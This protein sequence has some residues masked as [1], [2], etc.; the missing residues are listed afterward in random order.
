MATLLEVVAVVLRG[1]HPA[2]CTT[3][4]TTTP[5]SFTQKVEDW[6]AHIALACAIMG[7]AKLLVL[8]ARNQVI[9]AKPS[10]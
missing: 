2:V 6:E 9:A 1:E 5:P 10:K 7:K 4:T 3:C 8:H